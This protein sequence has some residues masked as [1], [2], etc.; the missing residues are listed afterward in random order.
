MHIVF[1]HIVHTPA[2]LGEGVV[3]VGDGTEQLLDS[4]RVALDGCL[5]L[6]KGVQPTR[7]IHLWLKEEEE[8][9]ELRRGWSGVGWE[10]EGCRRESEEEGEGCKMAGIEGREK[11]KPVNQ[12]SNHCPQPQSPGPD[13]SCV[14]AEKQRSEQ[15]CGTDQSRCIVHT[16]LSFSVITHVIANVSM[17]Q[18]SVLTCPEP[19]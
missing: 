11:A 15:T 16:I 6:C 1:F 17:S 19:P 13:F 10:G 7:L 18:Q 8:E 3:R 4:V 14:A 9:E 12:V 5:E 2:E